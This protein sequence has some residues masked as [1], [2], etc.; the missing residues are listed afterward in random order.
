[1]GLITTS[2]IARFVDKFYLTLSPMSVTAFGQQY[3][4]YSF[5]LVPRNTS[6]FDFYVVQDVTICPTIISRSVDDSG[7]SCVFNFQYSG[8]S[9]VTLGGVPITF[10]GGAAFGVIV[11]TSSTPYQLVA[12]TTQCLAVNCLQTINS[13][14]VVLQT[15]SFSVISQDD[16]NIDAAT[17]ALDDLVNSSLQ[18]LN[19]ISANATAAQAKIDQILNLLS[20]INFNMSELFPYQDFTSLRDQLDGVVDQIGQNYCQGPFD[21]VICWFKSTASIIIASVVAAIIVG[22]ICFVLY[23]K[24]IAQKLKTKFFPESDNH[25]VDTAEKGSGNFKTKPKEPSSEFTLLSTN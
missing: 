3:P 18:T 7:N 21:S 8:N 22:I 2:G 15:P 9:S 23:K 1:V 14:Y 4:S 17:G 6:D 5:S 19:E 20:T 25:E 11:D 13:T 10:I 24:G 12:G 16:L